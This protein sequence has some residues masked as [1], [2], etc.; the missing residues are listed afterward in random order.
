LEAALA[1]LLSSKLVPV[2]PEFPACKWWSIKCVQDPIVE[3]LTQGY[4]M[5]LSQSGCLLELEISYSC[6]VDSCCD[7]FEDASWPTVAL[8]RYVLLPTDEPASLCDGD[9]ITL[10][11][12]D[13][14]A[15]PC[16]DCPNAAP[17]IDWPATLTI[18][19][20]SSC[21]DEVD[22]GSECEHEPDGCCD[23][24]DEPHDKIF[25]ATLSSS[26]PALDGLVIP[27]TWFS[28]NIWWA[29]VYGYDGENG[30]LCGAA[31]CYLRIT[32]QCFIN[33]VPPFQ[34][35]WQCT[36]AAFCTAAEPDTSCV[37]TDD[38]G[39]PPIEAPVCDPLSIVFVRHL[40]SGGNDGS[41]GEC[42]G[43]T[44]TITITE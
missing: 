20:E 38:P 41:C 11:L 25:Y 19:S 40:K 16:G 23:L 18:I 6:G 30:T 10:A 7:S 13:Q 26:C 35:F 36:I 8:Y 2:N 33:P 3:E 14:A 21:T 4:R 28:S 5:V 24:G 37:I 15:D 32:Y 42:T 17:D 39:E 1:A 27:L 34:T 12:I 9:E 43:C 31:K 44:V 29:F 22:R